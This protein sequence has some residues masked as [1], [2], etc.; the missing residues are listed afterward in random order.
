M[1]PWRGGQRWA[2]TYNGKTPGPTLRVRPG[3]RL[4]V[5]LSNRLD[6]PTNLHVH[7]LHVSPNA[8]S[9]NVFVMIGPGEEHTYEYLIPADHPSGTFWY[10]PHHHGTVAEQVAAGM[11]GV[12]IIDDEL[13][14]LPP[15]ANT[16]ERIMVLSDPRI[17]TTSDVLRWS[18]MGMMQGR[19]GDGVP[20][21]AEAFSEGRAP[22]RLAVGQQE[23]HGELSG[24]RRRCPSSRRS[25]R[26]SA[27]RGSWVCTPTNLS[28]ASRPDAAH[29]A[30]S[31][32][33]TI[34]SRSAHPARW[35]TPRSSTELPWAEAA[36]RSGRTS[37]CPA[38]GVGAGTGVA[39]GAVVGAG[40]GAGRWLTHHQP[41]PAAK[42][43]LPQP[44]TAV[45]SRGP[46]SR[47]GLMA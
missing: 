31:P 22:R 13:D 12:I 32:R 46:K 29:E 39:L 44:A 6:S 19:F 23:L 28:F 24:F 33:R 25:A 43:P 34:T 35:A 18:M 16:T 38:S 37:R 27:S 15:I 10:H 20:G 30:C 36:L 17:G 8:A 2:L 3:D 45:K 11:A 14:T 7:G 9:D 4:R 26:R 1:V 21:R 5:T 47:A 42:T 40:V 41:P